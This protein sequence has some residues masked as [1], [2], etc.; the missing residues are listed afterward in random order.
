MQVARSFLFAFSVLIPTTAVAKIASDGVLGDSKVSIIY[1]AHDGHL[2]VDAG[3]HAI[4]TLE[5]IS[6]AGILTGVKPIAIIAPPFD[7]FDRNKLFILKTAGIGDIDFGLA[8]SPG[9]SEA[10]V[11]QD[12]S[13]NGSIL[14]NGTL[15]GGVDL[16]YVA[17]LTSGDLLIPGMFAILVLTLFIVVVDLRAGRQTERPDHGVN[18]LPR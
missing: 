12:L 1:D 4:T 15:P 3:G 5:I 11:L 10:E 6:T 16:I 17:P 18:A 2:A 7:V 9:L 14:P 13:I 8:A